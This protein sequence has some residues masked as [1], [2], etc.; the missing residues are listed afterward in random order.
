MRRLTASETNGSGRSMPAFVYILTNR[1]NGTL[2][3]GSTTN[4]E[5]R[6]N[7]HRNGTL[8][9]FTKRYGLR[10][11]VYIEAFRTLADARTQ[12]WRMKHWKREWKIEA[13]VA[14]NPSWRDLGNNPESF[15]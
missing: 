3:V 10:R 1:K 11:L 6:L 2:Y 15:D 9:G 4:I 14:K 12:E 7:E 13:I 8:E 5:N